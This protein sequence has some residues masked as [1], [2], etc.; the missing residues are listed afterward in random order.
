[1]FSEE[2]E[3]RKDAPTSVIKDMCAKWS[4]LHSFVE[5]YHPDNTAT[6]RAV[7]NFNDVMSHFRK[8]LKHRQKQVSLDKFLVKR[9]KSPVAESPKRKRLEREIT[10]EAELPEIFMEGDL[11]SKQ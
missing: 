8:V 1:M 11:S 3:G 10:P 2:D 9:K 6:S 5:L 7:N 4:E